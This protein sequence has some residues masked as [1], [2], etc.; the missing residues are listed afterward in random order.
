MGRSDIVKLWLSFGSSPL[1]D[2]YHRGIN[3]L[4]LTLIY[5]AEENQLRHDQDAYNQATSVTPAL[6]KTSKQKCPPI[7]KTFDQFECLIRHN[8]KAVRL[9][10]V[11]IVGILLKFSA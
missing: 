2:Q 9:F 7:S 5:V 3:I 1:V 4:A 6:V 11:H 8:L 10:C